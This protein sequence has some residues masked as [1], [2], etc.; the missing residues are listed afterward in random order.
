MDELLKYALEHGMIN[1]SYIQEQ[2]KMN[3]RREL[4][5]QHPYNIWEGK[6]GKWRT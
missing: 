3:K 5:E 4:L 1:M 2:I 6:D